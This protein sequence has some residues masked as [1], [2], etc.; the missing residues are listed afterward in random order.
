M[1]Y[2]FFAP[3]TESNLRRYE[4]WATADT[5]DVQFLGDSLEE[6]ACMLQDYRYI[7]LHANP[8]HTLTRT[9]P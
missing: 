7:T 8:S 4:T 2:F 1:K 6:C 9:S 5:Q 3:P